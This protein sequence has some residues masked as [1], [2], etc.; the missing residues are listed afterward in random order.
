MFIPEHD[1]T[2]A[3]SHRSIAFGPVHECKIEKTVDS[4]H[5][6]A[7]CIDQLLLSPKFK[8]DLQDQ[9]TNT[10]MEIDTQLEEQADQSPL[11]GLKLSL[12]KGQQEAAGSQFDNSE[13]AKSD[14][15]QHMEEHELDSDSDDE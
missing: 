13:S 2:N 4:K 7:R 14:Q 3:S 8:N 15:D 10:Q 12:V 11:R 1:L 9:R 6:S 5:D